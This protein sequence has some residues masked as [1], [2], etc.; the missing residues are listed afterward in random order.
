M[1]LLG[2]IGLFRPFQVKMLFNFSGRS[3]NIDSKNY[4]LSLDRTRLN[5]LNINHVYEGDYQCVVRNQ[6]G[7]VKSQFELKVLSWFPVY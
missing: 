7:E 1:K 4:A 3:I 6:A 5:I 2:F